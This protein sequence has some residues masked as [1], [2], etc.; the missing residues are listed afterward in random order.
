MA[1]KDINII[2]NRKGKVLTYPQVVSHRCRFFAL[3]KL[4]IQLDS[5][6]QEY[7]L[8]S[9]QPVFESCIRLRSQPKRVADPTSQQNDWNQR[10]L[11]PCNSGKLSYGS[12]V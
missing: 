2:A 4:S 7:L 6:C 9:I 5:W 8:A 3:I 1:W 12:F 11:L 10:S